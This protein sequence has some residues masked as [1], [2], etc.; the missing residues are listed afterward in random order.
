MRA[1][2]AL[3]SNL[4][5]R[6]A[7]LQ[8]AVAAIRTFAEPPVLVS[9]IYETPPVDCP[10]DSPMFLNAAIEIGFSGEPRD[11]LQRLQA[12][13]QFHDR[14]ANHGRNTP[15]TVDLDILYADDLE[16]HEPDLEL[17]HP[18][19]MDRLFVLMPLGDIVPNR[20]FAKEGPSVAQQRDRL[21]TFA[22]DEILI[23]EE[24]LLK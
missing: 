12:I 16:L 1:G 13:E 4:G 20:H 10:A 23:R 6:V 17:P 14:P 19:L 2:I 22:E 15:R 9:R 5:D 7:H 21:R 3:G 11:L 24:S 8:A 18:R